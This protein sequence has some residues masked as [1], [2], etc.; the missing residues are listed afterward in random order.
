MGMK[1]ENGSR[2]E[3]KPESHAKPMPTPMPITA[4]IPVTKAMYPEVVIRYVVPKDVIV[5]PPTKSGNPTAYPS[6]LVTARGV[7]KPA[8]TAALIAAELT[9]LQAATPAPITSA[10]AAKRTPIAIPIVDR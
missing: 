7:K 1:G 5:P 2:P 4:A 6:S 8:A 10:V 9:A 3:P